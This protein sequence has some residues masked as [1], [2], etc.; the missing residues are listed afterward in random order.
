M[1]L[2]LFE[3]SLQVFYPFLGS[4]ALR[5]YPHHA[6]PQTDEAP[7]SVPLVINGGNRINVELAVGLTLSIIFHYHGLIREKKST[8]A[9]HTISA[10]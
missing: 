8:R 5:R 6:D 10:E 7:F 9:T 3:R 4:E 2:V 1:A